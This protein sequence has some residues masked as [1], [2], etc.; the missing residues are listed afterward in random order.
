MLR[1]EN[2][3][4]WRALAIIIHVASRR[5]CGTKT[6]FEIATRGMN[7][8]DPVVSAPPVYIDCLLTPL[9]VG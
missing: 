5:I 1:H 4:R 3:M 8:R 6:T 2:G 9:R 7:G